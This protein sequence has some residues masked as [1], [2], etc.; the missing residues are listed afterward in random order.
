MSRRG[1]ERIVAG[2]A[3]VTCGV[4]VLGYLSG[5]PRQDGIGPGPAAATAERPATP[6]RAASRPAGDPAGP[7]VQLSTMLWP[8]G[9]G[10]GRLAWSVT[11]PPMTAACRAALGRL[12]ILTNEPVGPCARSRPRDPEAIITGWVGTRHVTAW[13]DQRDGCGARRWAQL[14][15]LLTPPNDRSPARKEVPGAG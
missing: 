3:I 14:L 15:P 13:V 8:H 6:I 12:R 10:R 11:C 5:I 2:L 1:D 9:P 4:A 7:E